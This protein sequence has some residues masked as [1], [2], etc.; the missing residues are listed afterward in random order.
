MKRN[1]RTCLYA[2]L[3]FLLPAAHQNATAAEVVALGA[4][5]VQGVGV[6]ASETWPAILQE[7][8]RARGINVTVKNAGIGGQTSAEILYRAEYAL[9]GDTKVV[10]LMVGG[11]DLVKGGNKKTR[12]TNIQEIMQR[13]KARGVTVIMAGHAYAGLNKQTQ[14]S[15]DGRHPNAAGNRAIANAVLGQVVAGLRR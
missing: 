10:L 7:M 2:G 3:L 14:I 8:L 5:S 4:S 12:A 13:L 9:D 11:N 15:V 1:F 6:S